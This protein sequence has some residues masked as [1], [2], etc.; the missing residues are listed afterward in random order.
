MLSKACASRAG[1]MVRTREVGWSGS[2]W[3]KGV[4]V[5]IVLLM[6][7]LEPQ[8]PLPF[9]VSSSLGI[10]SQGERLTE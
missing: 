5:M 7:S 4:S 6:L 10:G 2:R 9:F 3:A 1:V 8:F